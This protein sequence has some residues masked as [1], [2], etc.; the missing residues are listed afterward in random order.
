MDST[1][2]RK[3]RKTKIS[4][5]SKAKSVETKMSGNCNYL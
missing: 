5:K 4:S 2:D 3:Q 1:E